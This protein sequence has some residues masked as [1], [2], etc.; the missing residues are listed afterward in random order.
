MN[1]TPADSKTWLNYYNI[2]NIIKTLNYYK[3]YY[4]QIFFK[5]FRNFFLKFSEFS[6]L[7]WIMDFWTD[8]NR[9]FAMTKN[10]LKKPLSFSNEGN[11]WKKDEVNIWLKSWW[12][13]NCFCSFSWNKINDIKWYKKTL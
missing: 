7:L 12:W 1:F 2:I 11:I 13:G 3:I 8:R 5:N 6:I 4:I 9:Q 10:W